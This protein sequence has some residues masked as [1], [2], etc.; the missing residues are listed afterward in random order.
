MALL[1]AC[2]DCGTEGCLVLNSVVD[3]GPEMI[4]IGFE[5]DFSDYFG[6]DPA[7]IFSNIFN[8]T[9]NAHFIPE[10]LLRE[11]RFFRL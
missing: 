7:W 5:S 11:I 8:I 9:L 2:V 1:A 6:S 10:I 4:F 3:T